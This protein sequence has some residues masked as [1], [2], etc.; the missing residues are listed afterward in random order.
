ME[1]TYTLIWHIAS[2]NLSSREAGKT[3]CVSP[4]CE[5]TLDKADRALDDFAVRK[6]NLSRK[7]HKEDK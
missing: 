2:K 7:S 3:N 6:W 5:E 1:K 4:S